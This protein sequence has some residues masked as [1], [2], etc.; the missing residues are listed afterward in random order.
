[1]SDTEAQPLVPT[2]KPLLWFLA[3]A[4]VYDIAGELGALLGV[5]FLLFGGLFYAIGASRARAVS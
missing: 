4:L 5:G 1:M 2:I 3:G